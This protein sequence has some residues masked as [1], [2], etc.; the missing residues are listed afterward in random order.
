MSDRIVLVPHGDGAEAQ[1]I[2]DA[3]ADRTG[4]EPDE[5]TEGVEFLLGPDDHGIEVVAT[6]NEIDPGWTDHLALGDPG[7]DPD[8]EE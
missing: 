3:F 2:I 1:S 5:L 4:L 8:S 7:A 6:L